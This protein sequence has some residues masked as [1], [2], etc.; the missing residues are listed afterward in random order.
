VGGCESLEFLRC[1]DTR[2]TV[3]AYLEDAIG[4]WH[5]QY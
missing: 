1:K 2:I 3:F 4:R 5:L